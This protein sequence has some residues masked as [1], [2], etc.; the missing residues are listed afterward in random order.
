M[1]FKL[2]LTKEEIALMDAIEIYEYVLSGRLKKFPMG[3]WKDS[4]GFNNAVKCFKYLIEDK[5]NWSDDD[6]KKHLSRKIFIEYRL[7]GMFKTYFDG[8]PYSAIQALYPNKFKPWDMAVCPMGYWDNEENCIKAIK[9]LIE[10]KLQWSDI[11]IR[12]KLT[13]DVF[14]ENGLAGMS[15]KYKD[16]TY[17]LIN[18]AYPNRFKPW[19]LVQT[20]P[21]FWK[22]EQ[23]K[24]TALN[25]L[26]EEVLNWSDDEIREKFD[27][28]IL[29]KYGLFGLLKNHF[30][31]SPFELLNYYY[32]NRFQEWELKQTPKNF[33]DKKDN[34]IRCVQWLIKKYNL[35]DENI[36]KV[37]TRSFLIDNNVVSLSNYHNG[38]VYE[39]LN[40]VYPNKF[41]PWEISVPVNG[42]WNNIENRR[43]AIKW[44]IEKKLQWSDD[45]VYTNLVG[46]IFYENGL[47]GLL[48]FYYNSNAWTALN[49]AYP[50][51]FEPTLFKRNILPKSYWNNRDNR[52]RSITALCNRLNIKNKEF[53][54]LLN[55]DFIK[56]HNLNG[57]YNFYNRDVNELIKD[58]F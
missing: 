29:I 26:F 21:T 8:S 41:K 13:G 14:Y 58:I 27:A 24:Q 45:D 23:N 55:D 51:K 40:E 38:N 15:S 3:Y 54:D 17:T 16:S 9:W 12:E 34:R 10:E 53:I 1:K 36:S 56:K 28:N 33:W 43:L 50:N 37:W 5:L 49:D 52:I 2:K 32:P 4:E 6:I 30:N 7:Y 44:L 42:H 11:D 18:L 25:W 31:G 57:I 47:S 46:N 22:D 19:E 20:S 48:N 35:T 39:V